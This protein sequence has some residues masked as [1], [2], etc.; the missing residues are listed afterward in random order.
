MKIVQMT[1]GTPALPAGTQQALHAAAERSPL[2]RQ[3]DPANRRWGHQ[4][5]HHY[6]STQ[7]QDLQG[8]T[9]A[10]FAMRKTLA[11]RRCP[12]SEAGNLMKLNFRL[13]VIEDS[14]AAGAAATGSTWASR[15]TAA[16]RR[17][18]GE[19]A[20]RRASAA[21]CAAQPVRSPVSSIAAWPPSAC[22]R[23]GTS[24][25]NSACSW[26]NGYTHAWTSRSLDV[27]A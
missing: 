10:L 2:P 8:R 27:D 23:R 12:A 4:D 1:G 13:M 9:I 19:G 5:Y 11:R 7:R 17:S 14:L 20:P 25:Q 3:C 26:G 24:G 16:L 6:A 21:R 22:V 18:A 15:K